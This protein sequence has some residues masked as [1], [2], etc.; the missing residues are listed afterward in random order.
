MNKIFL[1]GRLT[2]D[3]APSTTQSGR[4]YCRFSLAVNRDYKDPDGNRTADFFNCVVW[5]EQANTVIRY[6]KKGSP[7]LIMGC[8]QV[9]NYEG[10]DGSRR[11]SWDIRVDQFWFV[12]GSG[13]GNGRERLPEPEEPPYPVNKSSADAG[14]DM[15]FDQA[16][17][18]PDMPF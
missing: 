9:R 14:N 11:R 15:P 12:S 1:Q 10:Q 6:F 17:V 5:G 3:P 2:E 7:I 18:D 13:N 8:V 4:N 16:D